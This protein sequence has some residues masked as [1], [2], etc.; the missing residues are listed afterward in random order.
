MKRD[1]DYNISEINYMLD[2]IEKEMYVHLLPVAMKV[3]VHFQF[4][5]YGRTRIVSLY[6]TADSRIFK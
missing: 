3:K 5:H 4:A 6:K 1:F 2:F